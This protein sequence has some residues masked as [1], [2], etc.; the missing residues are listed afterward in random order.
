MFPWK[1]QHT[2]GSYPKQPSTTCFWRKS[3]H[4]CILGYLGYIPGVCWEFFKI[5]VNVLPREA[6]EENNR[7]IILVGDLKINKPWSTVFSG[8][9]AG[10]KLYV[11]YSTPPKVNMSPKNRPLQQVKACLPTTDFLV[12]GGVMVYLPALRIIGP[13]NDAVWTCIAGVGS[14]FS[15]GVQKLNLK[16]DDL[17]STWIQFQQ[18]FGENLCL[19][20]LVRCF[21]YI[22]FSRWENPVG[23]KWGI[24]YDLLRGHEV[25][26]VAATEPPRSNKDPAWKKA[27][28]F[29]KEHGC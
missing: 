7:I 14:P 3:S 18:E 26:K 2:P 10:P 9:L 17:L 20:H 19:F 29:L 4:F 8:V 11:T 24:S 25:V 15:G 22:F 13:S 21:A 5:D 12:F 1:F 6:K 23:Q 27:L 16:V 28:K